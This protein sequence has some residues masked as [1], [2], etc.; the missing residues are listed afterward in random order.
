M[1][2]QA[3]YNVQVSR[4][5]TQAAQLFLVAFL[6]RTVLVL[7]FGGGY[8][9]LEQL[10]SI[11]DGSVFLRIAATFPLVYDTPESVLQFPMYPAVIWVFQFFLQPPVAAILASML[12]SSMA[13]SVTYLIGVQLGLDAR[14]AALIFCVFPIKWFNGSVTAYAES[15]LVLSELCWVLCV[16]KGSRLGASVSLAVA[17]LT[18]ITAVWLFPVGLFILFKGTRP[19]RHAALVSALAGAFAL[20]CLFAYFWLRFGDFLLYV[21]GP[22]DAGP[23]F[24]WPGEALI[25][26][27]LGDAFWVRKPYVVAVFCFYLSAVILSLKLVP[28]DAGRVLLIW[29][30][31]ILVPVLCIPAATAHTRWL[32]DQVVWGFIVFTRHCVPA[33]PAAMLVI[34]SKIPERYRSPLLVLLACGSFG[35]ASWLLRMRATLPKE[36]LW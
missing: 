25:R 2:D 27:L 13:V 19:Q 7:H 31:S 6:A 17:V 16:L 15:L 18:K 24:A 26:G 34:G 12:L 4:H 1:R 11:D 20:T 29:I 30:A 10:A 21:R 35:C 22:A 28:R 23:Y 36:V 33:A 32:P 3:S 9:F 5:H 8:A 14:Y